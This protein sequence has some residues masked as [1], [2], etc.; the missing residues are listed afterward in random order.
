[1]NAEKSRAVGVS[2]LQPWTPPLHGSLHLT[3]SSWS[4]A[5]WRSQERSCRAAHQKSLISEDGAKPPLLLSSA[6]LTP[7]C[8]FC[9]QGVAD[10]LTDLEL[11]SCLLRPTGTRR[12]LRGFAFTASAFRILPRYEGGQA[13]VRKSLIFVITREQSSLE[14]PPKVVRNPLRSDLTLPLCRGSCELNV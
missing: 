5:D 3:Q 12:T 7:R 14:R 9:Q 10:T 13:V 1:V 2:G 11:S 6:S 8:C 4:V